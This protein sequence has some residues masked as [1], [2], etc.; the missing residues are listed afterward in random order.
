MDALKFI[1][2]V[3]PEHDRTS[4]SDTDISNGFFTRNCETWHGRCK[5]CM[6]LQVLEGK[7]L[8]DGFN[9]FECVG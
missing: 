3:V 4:C 6:Y 1:N 9:D 5:R 8:P 7:E 2:L